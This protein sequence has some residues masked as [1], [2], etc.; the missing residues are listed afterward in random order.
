MMCEEL[1][2]FLMIVII[3]TNTARIRIRYNNNNKD[4]YS[5][6]DSHD[7]IAMVTTTKR[8]TKAMKG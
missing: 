2:V 3:F 4:D 5:H 7:K 1:D 6:G 8:V